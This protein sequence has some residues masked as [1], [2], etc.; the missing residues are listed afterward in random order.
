MI[1]QEDSNLKILTLSSASMFSL[2]FVYL[3]RKW[4]DIIQGNL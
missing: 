4:Q 1:A 3:S 2:Y